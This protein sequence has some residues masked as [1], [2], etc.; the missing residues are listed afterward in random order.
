MDFIVFRAA[1]RR[2]KAVDTDTR[3]IAGL[4]RFERYEGV[5]NCCPTGTLQMATT[6]SKNKQT[7]EAYLLN[8]HI[9]SPEPL[10]TLPYLRSPPIHGF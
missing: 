3:V 6:E 8:K 9:L 4:A 1:I 7:D 5:R 2:R 10:C